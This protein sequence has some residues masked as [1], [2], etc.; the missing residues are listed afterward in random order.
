MHPERMLGASISR[1]Q[2]SRS[3]RTLL[4][5]ASVLLLEAAVCE[6]GQVARCGIPVF[7]VLLST[8]S[9]RGALQD[10]AGP[11]GPG[12]SSRR[13]EGIAFCTVQMGSWEEIRAGKDEFCYRS[14]EGRAVRGKQSGPRSTFHT[15]FPPLW[16]PRAAAASIPVTRVEGLRGR[17]ASAADRR[18]R[19][20][21]GG[22]S[23][24]RRRR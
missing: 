13:P 9:S 5:P 10:T 11:L 15:R 4:S 14:R 6:E 1:V 7:Q 18:S 22:E 24:H 12:E 8:P 16:E 3:G 17:G 2:H 21:E 19:R 20:A 23:A